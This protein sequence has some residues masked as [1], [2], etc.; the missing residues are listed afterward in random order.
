MTAKNNIVIALSVTGWVGFARLSRAQV[1]SLRRRDHVLAAESLGSSSVFIVL[2]SVSKLSGWLKSDV[3]RIAL[4]VILKS[5]GY[6]TTM[7]TLAHQV[8]LSAQ[9]RDFDQYAINKL[10]I[11]GTV[12][13]ERAGEAAFKILKKGK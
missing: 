9:V 7:K 2:A 13:M 6:H 11:S 10:A 3:C 4:I 12:L 5:W 1:L 8:Y